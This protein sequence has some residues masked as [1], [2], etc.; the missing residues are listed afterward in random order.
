LGSFGHNSL[1]YCAYFSSP[2][3]RVIIHVR[4]F[5]NFLSPNII[6]LHIYNLGSIVFAWSIFS[7]IMH[8]NSPFDCTNSVL[9][10]WY[11]FLLDSWCKICFFSFTSYFITSLLFFPNLDIKSFKDFQ[12]MHFANTYPHF[13]TSSFKWCI[14]LNLFIAYW[15]I[16]P[17]LNS[18]FIFQPTNTEKKK[19]Y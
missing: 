15:E 4:V 2:W 11:K 8:R 19:K 10:V 1:E 16:P 17:M 9:Q 7:W 12:T 3:P 6:L 18:L 14:F 13:C 5:G